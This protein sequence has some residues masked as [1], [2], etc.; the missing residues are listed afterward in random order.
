MVKIKLIISFA[1]LWKISV[2][3]PAQKQED[4][5]SSKPIIIILWI[6]K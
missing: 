5:G 4:Y 1:M 2:F 6:N 3:P